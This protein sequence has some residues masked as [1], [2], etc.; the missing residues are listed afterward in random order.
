MYNSHELDVVRTNKL[1]RSFGCGRDAM[2]L[3]MDIQGSLL[4][5]L[6]TFSLCFPLVSQSI[7][8]RKRS[9]TLLETT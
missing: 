8:T 5:M 6:S 2:H 4:P 3:L 1:F 7:A 9:F